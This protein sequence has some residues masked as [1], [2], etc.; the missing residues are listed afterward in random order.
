ME[1]VI[2]TIIINNA[3]KSDKLR[4]FRYCE[5]CNLPLNPFLSIATAIGKEEKTPTRKQ[6]FLKCCLSVLGLTT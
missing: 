5:K 2:N 4:S 3:P 6:C 1:L